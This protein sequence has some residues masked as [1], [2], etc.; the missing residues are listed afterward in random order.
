MVGRK[1]CTDCSSSVACGRLDPHPA[2]SA[3]PH[4]LAVCNAVECDPS[5]EAEILHTGLAPDG[6]SERENDPFQDQLDGRRQVHVMLGE[7]LVRLARWAAEKIV[8]LFV[9]HSQPGAV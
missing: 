1:S 3:L 9:C 6:L 8:E 2:K 7:Q 5:R 4:D